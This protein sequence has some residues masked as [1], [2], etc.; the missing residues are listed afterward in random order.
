MKTKNAALTIISVVVHLMVIFVIA[1]VIYRGATFCYEFG[2]RVFT[3]RPMAAEPGRD[4]TVIINEGSSTKE[5]GK[6]LQQNGLISDANLFVLHEKIS[7]Y[8]GEIK[9]GVYVLNT[10]MTTEKMIA[11]MSGKLAEDEEKEKE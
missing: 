3:D 10:S 9:P 5:I 2:Y 6:I 7:E 4:I 11:V 8:A 1:M